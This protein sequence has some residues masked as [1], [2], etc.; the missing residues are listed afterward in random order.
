MALDK[1]SYLSPT[2]TAGTYVNANITV[3]D[4][5][6]I[7]A[8][9]TGGD[10]SI[11]AGTIASFAQTVAPLGWTQNTL[12]NNIGV[13]IVSGTGG[14][15]GGTI[16]FSTL[17]TTGVTYS[18]PINITSGQVNDTVL[19]EGQLPS[20]THQWGIADGGGSRSGG[21]GE[22][23]GVPPPAFGNWP[24]SY[25]GG[26]PHSHSLSGV[27]ASGSFVGNL[28]LYYVDIILASKN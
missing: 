6:R 5:G 20:H 2:V 3:N 18:G 11:P 21:G 4:Q 15:T 23:Q 10:T 12:Y 14:G 17:F 22:A 7:T 24:F 19:N 28:N 25:V 16:P 26:N 9:A 13:R 27:T 8:I 1:V